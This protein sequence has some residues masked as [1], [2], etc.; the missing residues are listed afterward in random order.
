MKTL[1]PIGSL[2]HVYILPTLAFITYCYLKGGL[3]PPVL[4]PFSLTVVLL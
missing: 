2:I 3:A 4:L 1:L